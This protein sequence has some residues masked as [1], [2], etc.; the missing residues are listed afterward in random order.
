MTDV[1]GNPKYSDVKASMTEE[2]GC[3]GRQREEHIGIF[4]VLSL[5]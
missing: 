3:M 1:T 2:Q 4:D 5:L